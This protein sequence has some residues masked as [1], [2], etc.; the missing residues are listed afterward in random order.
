MPPIKN[1]FVINFGNMLE[2]WTG[3]TIPATVHRVVN[4]SNSERYSSPYFLRPSLKTVLNP[5]HFDESL[6][7]V[8]TTCEEVLTG[9]Y[10]RANLL[11]TAAKK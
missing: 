6:P 8:E 10:T 9:F 7:D 3:N 11:K 2:K 4:L 5:K 1:A